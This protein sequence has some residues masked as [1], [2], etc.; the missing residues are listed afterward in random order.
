MAGWQA[1]ALAA[2]GVTVIG[3]HIAGFDRLR[4]WPGAAGDSAGRPAA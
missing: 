2:D 3:R 1:A 4:W